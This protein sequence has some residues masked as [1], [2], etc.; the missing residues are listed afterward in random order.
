[1]LKVEP[2][3]IAENHFFSI[4]SQAWKGKCTTSCFN[5]TMESSGAAEIFELMG[6]YI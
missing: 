1:M 5:V 6:V 4:I 2:Y 3:Y